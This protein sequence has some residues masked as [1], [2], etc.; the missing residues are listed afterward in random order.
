MSNPGAGA[1]IEKDLLD[2][3]KLANVED[4]QQKLV[5]SLNIRR[6]D[7]ISHVQDKEFQAIG[8]SQLQ[9]QELRRC[10]AQ[11]QQLVNNRNV[12][13]EIVFI[14][15]ENLANS[16]SS[17]IKKAII[18]KEQIKIMETIGEGTFSVVK[19]AI[20]YH[21]SGT[22]VDVAL[23]ILRD[24]SPSLIEDLEVEASHLLKLQHPNLIR[25]FGIVQQPAMMFVA[26]FE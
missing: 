21:P 19:R 6:L 13:S 7:H 11:V 15:N 10:T 8:L 26:Q 20:W 4:F 16:S 1:S 2:V 14:P 17:E 18:A 25:L 12:K 24:V 23:K 5:F 9:I 22:K 3:W